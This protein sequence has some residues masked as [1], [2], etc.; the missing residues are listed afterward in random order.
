MFVNPLAP[1]AEGMKSLIVAMTKQPATAKS[2]SYRI[3]NAP[4]YLSFTAEKY[5]KKH[6]KKW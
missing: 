1:P 2:D 3:W 4:P 6:Q 5:Y